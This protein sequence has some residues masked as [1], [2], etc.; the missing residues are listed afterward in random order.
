MPPVIFD[1]MKNGNGPP[2]VAEDDRKAKEQ[3]A[4]EINESADQLMVTAPAGD[5]GPSVLI[6][7]LPNALWSFTLEVWP[8][9]TVVPLSVSPE[10]IASTHQSPSAT[11]VTSTVMSSA[12]A[13]FVAVAD[14][15]AS[16][17]T[18]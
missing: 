16:V 4:Q 14:V 8:A 18:V 17:G 12:D 2:L 10:T 1:R 5:F 15:A 11:V 6:A 9:P 13:P 3:V 7:A